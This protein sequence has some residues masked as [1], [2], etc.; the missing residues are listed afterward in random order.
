MF[1]TAILSSAETRK[2]NLPYHILL[3]SIA[4][5]EIPS[6]EIMLTSQGK[7]KMTKMQAVPKQNTF[8]SP[9]QC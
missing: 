8:K 5:C 2:K 9:I 6:E 4:L 3:M 7:G 1:Q